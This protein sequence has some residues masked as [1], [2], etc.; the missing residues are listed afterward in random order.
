MSCYEMLRSSQDEGW[1]HFEGLPFQAQSEKD[2]KDETGR[3][4]WYEMSP[5]SS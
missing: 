4:E 3:K 1:L 2:V 5:R